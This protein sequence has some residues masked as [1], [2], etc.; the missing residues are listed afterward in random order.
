MIYTET[1]DY[2]SDVCWQI[3]KRMQE[4]RLQ[5][6]LL[7]VEVAAFL[8]INKNQLSRIE[9]GKANCTISQLY[10]LTQLYKCTSDYLLFGKEQETKLTQA[11][12]DAITAI[13]NVF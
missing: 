2:D 13:K 7:G 5:R 4:T 6:G 9:N 11:Q 3:G 10:V 8:D 1:V 12:Q